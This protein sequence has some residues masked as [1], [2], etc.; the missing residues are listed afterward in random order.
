ML[1]EY[2]EKTL[3]AQSIDELWAHLGEQMGVF[4]FDRLLYGFTYNRKDN[5]LGDRRDMLI[6]S[7]H[8]KAYTEHFIEDGLFF[9]APMTHWALSHSGL[10][11]WSLVEDIQDELMESQLEILRFNQE[12]GVV[13]GATISFPGTKR[14]SIAAIGL[15]AKPGMTQ[16]DVDAV[17]KDHGREILVINQFTHLKMTTLPFAGGNSP[18]TRRQRQA[19]ECIGDGMNTQEAAKKMGLTA[20]TVEK[21]LRLARESLS[22]NTT[23]QAINKASFQNQIYIVDD[24]TIF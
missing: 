6:L 18:L 19:L 7:S 12:S 10:C 11:S 2:I 14:R 17:L 13:A 4:G 15:T 1:I 23:A 20:A 3:S 16:A 9:D 21:H 24:V 22:V 5:T 8:A